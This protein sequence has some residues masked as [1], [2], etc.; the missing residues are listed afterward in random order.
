MLGFAILEAS[1]K[2][3]LRSA[4]PARGASVQ[5]PCLIESSARVGAKPPALSLLS[6][7]DTFS[8]RPVIPVKV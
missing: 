1:R 8:L 7:P 5:V 6:A 3:Q 2:E 4:I